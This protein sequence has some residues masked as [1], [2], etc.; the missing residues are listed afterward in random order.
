MSAASNSLAVVPAIV[1]SATGALLQPDV[2]LA[3]Q[4]A[5]LSTA[6]WFPLFPSSVSPFVTYKVRV[7]ESKVGQSGR[8]PTLVIVAMGE[9]RDEL[10]ALQCRPSITEIVLSPGFGT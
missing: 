4:F 9:Q 6:T 8:T 2:S 7:K 3:L 5:T 1:T 10:V